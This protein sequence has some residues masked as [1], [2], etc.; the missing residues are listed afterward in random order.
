MVRWGGQ[1]NVI[2]EVTYMVTKCTGIIPITPKLF[3]ASKSK[4]G[5]IYKRLYGWKAVVSQVPFI[6][7]STIFDRI[8]TDAW[9]EMRNTHLRTG[10]DAMCAKV[11]R[12]L[13]QIMTSS[14]LHW[15]LV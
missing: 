8:L 14:R 5:A 12:N 7:T 11:L 15:R 3:S 4:I 10:T 1:P 13:S 6:T 9:L 2:Y